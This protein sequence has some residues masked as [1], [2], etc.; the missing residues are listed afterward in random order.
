MHNPLK[1][2]LHH[3]LKILIIPP[4]FAKPSQKCTFLGGWGAGGAGGYIKS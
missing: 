4:M 2:F 3:G 1:N